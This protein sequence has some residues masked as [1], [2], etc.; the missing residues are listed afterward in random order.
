MVPITSQ[1]HCLA[2]GI[3]NFLL[4]LSKSMPIA[5]TNIGGAM[6]GK[7]MFIYL[8]KVIMINDL[9]GSILLRNSNYSIQVVA[10]EYNIDS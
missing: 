8:P 6:K 2:N 3:I 10:I 5:Y 4:N 1:G 9:D 7:S